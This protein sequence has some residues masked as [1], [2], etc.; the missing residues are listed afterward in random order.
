MPLARRNPTPR[1]AVGLD[2][3]GSVY[4][5]MVEKN[6]TSMGLTLSNLADFATTLGITQLLN[7]DGGS[8][9]SLQAEGQVSFGRADADN[10]PIQRPVKSVILAQ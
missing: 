5:L 7:L 6:E 1:S 8:S 9:S 4:L 10:Q 2:A 3:T